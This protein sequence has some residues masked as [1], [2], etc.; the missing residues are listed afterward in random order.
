L[1][2]ASALAKVLSE[3]RV[4]HLHTLE[5]KSVYDHDVNR[6]I[7]A[8]GKLHV[9][10]SNAASQ[11]ER[12]TQQKAKNEQS[13]SLP[14]PP[15]EEDENDIPGKEKSSKPA[16][17][18]KAYRA[19]ALKTHPDKIENDPSI[20]DAMRDRL[21]ELYKQASDAYALDDFQTIAEIAAE[22]E[23]ETGMPIAEL[24][25]ALETKI[26]SLRNE[27]IKLQRTVSWTWGTSFG[28][29]PL[30]IQ[31]LKR[32]CQLMNIQVPD[33]KVLAEII[34]ELESQPDFD[35]TDRLGRVKRVKSGAERRK[36]GQR[37]ERFIR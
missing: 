7:L 19:I 3:L 5:R 20:S 26:S 22:L 6:A 30:R 15:Q 36:V 27:T 28:N 23:I 9:I 21:V 31:V 24:E 8:L 4:E 32:C 18:R 2:R 10:E 11:D 12:R 14:P 1:S 13:S 17:V 35:I 37:P 33:D 29:I 16:W 34:K 25:T